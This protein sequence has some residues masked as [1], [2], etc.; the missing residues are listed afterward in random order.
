MPPGTVPESI[1][2]HADPVS[3]GVE[4]PLSAPIAGVRCYVPRTIRRI[5]GIL[6]IESSNGQGGRATAD[7]RSAVGHSAMTWDR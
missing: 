5:Q 4:L 6:Q 2:L 7:R 3:P 1:E